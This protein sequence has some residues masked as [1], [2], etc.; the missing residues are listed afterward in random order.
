MNISILKAES[1][2]IAARMA[3]GDALDRLYIKCEDQK[4][5]SSRVIE[6]ELDSIREQMKD[7]AAQMSKLINQI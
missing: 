7:Y 2:K 1:I 6:R 5:I 3:R 4:T